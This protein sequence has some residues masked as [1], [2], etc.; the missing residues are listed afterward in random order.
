M[1]ICSIEVPGIA[2][3]SGGKEGF[4]KK[5]MK[6][7]LALL[8]SA[9]MVMSLGVTA[10]AGEMPVEEID[11]EAAV[12]TE[13]T[14]EADV[15]NR[16]EGDYWDVVPDDWNINSI[17]TTWNTSPWLVP[18]EEGDIEDYDDYTILSPF[19]YYFTKES[20]GSVV[21]I[22]DGKVIVT[23]PTYRSKYDDDRW[24]YRA[25]EVGKDDLYILLR[26]NVI[27]GSNISIN[28]S[29]YENGGKRVGNQYMED[30]FD[31]TYGVMAKDSE[32]N[33][34]KKVDP[35]SQKRATNK[36]LNSTNNQYEPV[37]EYDGRKKV[38]V[39]L[40]KGK[41][42]KKGEDQ[43][44]FVKAKLVQRPASANKIVSVWD[45]PIK[46]VQAKNNINATLPAYN[47]VT[48]VDTTETN[49]SYGFT[50]TTDEETEETTYSYTGYKSVPMLTPADN[51]NLKG[52]DYAPYFTVKAK[53][54]DK[55]AKKY[56]GAVNKALKNQ[57]FGFQIARFSI[58]TTE[59][60][61]LPDTI[62]YYGTPVSKEPL[63]IAQ[64]S[65][66]EEAIQKAQA[67]YDEAL[68]AEKEKMQTFMEAKLAAFKAAYGGV[69]KNYIT[70]DDLQYIFYK[71]SVD[72][73]SIDDVFTFD[74]DNDLK[75]AGSVNAGKGRESYG[76]WYGEIHVKPGYTYPLYISQALDIDVI[77]SNHLND[78][79]SLQVYDDC[80]S[81]DLFRN[82]LDTSNMKGRTQLKLN[83]KGDKLALKLYFSKLDVQVGKSKVIDTILELLTGV[84]NTGAVNYIYWLVRMGPEFLPF[85]RHGK[86]MDYITMP[87]ALRELIAIVQYEDIPINLDHIDV[88]SPESIEAVVNAIVTALKSN[89][90]KAITSIAL[91]K[92]ISLLV[93]F[94]VPQSLIKKIVKFSVKSQK[95]KTF[96]VKEGKTAP[97]N[98]KVD[99]LL[100]QLNATYADGRTNPDGTP[101][102]YPVMVLQ[103]VNNMEGAATMRLNGS[104]IEIGNYKDDNTYW[105]DSVE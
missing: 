26:Y 13:S 59:Y 66:D 43:C 50:K 78:Y 1:K 33:Y 19:S 35:A 55:E 21:D 60:D 93:G 15:L 32:G 10:F 71:E 105:V 52:T 7:L 80:L 92:V 30:Y 54:T 4:M 9:S 102:L 48:R 36:Y 6:K 67:A 86:S 16:A 41:A 74:A 24:Y 83:K 14:A 20:P 17:P 63:I 22:I 2:G 103:G 57:K 82:H 8:L 27:D 28:P 87:S 58:G 81:N 76:A 89:E 39:D 68:A 79:G 100:H 44:I 31:C 51:V 91:Q 73:V 97:A 18:I 96:F 38:W 3:G 45:L 69:Y 95:V 37:V 99:V 34:Q 65:G 98:K 61:T 12:L 75:W 88:N 56:N 94:G 101:M 5:R 49:Y 25:I 40:S 29:G 42:S 104:K 64:E 77:S 84:G 53:I 47:I 90:G 23:D 70:K 72:D 62:T 11:A 46:K 85:G